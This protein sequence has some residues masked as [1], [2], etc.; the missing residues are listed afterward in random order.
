[1][2]VVKK[3]FIL[4]SFPLFLGSCGGDSRDT[5]SSA[6]ADNPSKQLQDTIAKACESNC[7]T[8]VPPNSPSDQLKATLKTVDPNSMSIASDNTP[9]VTLRATIDRLSNSQQQ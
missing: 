5:M 4:I 9:S 2:L 1:M 8:S 7:N 6:P 3:F